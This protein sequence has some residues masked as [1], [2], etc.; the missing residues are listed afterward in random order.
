MNIFVSYSRRDGEVTDQSLRLIERY[1]NGIGTPFIHCFQPKSR[2]EQVSVLLALAKSHVVLLV[3][4]P[5]AKTSPWVRLE[6]TIAKLLLR[7]VLRLHA[8]DLM[9]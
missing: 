9:V 6:L 4:S 7:P 1:L 3:D 2:C 5:A 8:K